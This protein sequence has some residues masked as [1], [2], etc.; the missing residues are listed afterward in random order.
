MSSALQDL[1][2]FGGGVFLTRNGID[3]RVTE[4]ELWRAFEEPVVVWVHGEVFQRF[5]IG[6]A[7]A[8]RPPFSTDSALSF[9]QHASYTKWSSQTL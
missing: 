8:N 7:S 5:R 1:E 3:S 4:A 9:H 6:S 2:K